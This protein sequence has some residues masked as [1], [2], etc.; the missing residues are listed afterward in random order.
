MPILKIGDSCAT[1]PPNSLHS[2]KFVLDNTIDCWSMINVRFILCI[3]LGNKT[4]VLLMDHFGYGFGQW[5]KALHSKAS[6]HWLSP[7]PELSLLLCLDIL[8][9]VTLD[10]YYQFWIFIIT[11]ELLYWSCIYIYTLSCRLVEDVSLCNHHGIERYYNTGTW[12]IIHDDVIKWKHFPRYW[13]CVRG[14]PRLPVNSPHKGQWR[15]AWC[16]L[17]FASE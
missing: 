13:P 5:Q 3:Y 16:L 6:S 7:Y 2:F 8:L 4:I 1:T 14:I 11:P 15:G 17:W 10:I 9:C 12:V